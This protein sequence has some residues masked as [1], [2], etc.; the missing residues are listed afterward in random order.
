M[1]GA[2]GKRGAFVPRVFVDQALAPEAEVALT[3]AKLHHLKTVLRLEVG[4]AV[5]LFDGAGG[6]YPGRLTTLDRR[7]AVVSLGAI[8]QPGRE[9][10]LA[11][12]LAQGLATSERMDYALAKAVE[13]GV[14]AIQ[15]LLTARAKGGV[16]APQLE[17]KRA[18]W[19]RIAIASA[20][21]SGRERVPDIHPAV[22][23]ADWLAVP[24][25]GIRLV[26]DPRG[27]QALRAL[28]PPQQAVVLVGPEAGL[29]ATEIAAARDAGFIPIALGPRVLRTE[30]AGPAALCAL[31][32]LW[33]DLG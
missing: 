32:T 13:L 28:A 2:G 26:L 20:E 11:T 15:P 30:T 21:Q 6:E 25:P 5:V 8:R 3:G 9:S 22:A 33:G 31:Q 29:A 10:P 7:Q 12:T 18:H 4:S 24:P 1:S 14:T 16:A 27:E 19:Q 23:L 17:K